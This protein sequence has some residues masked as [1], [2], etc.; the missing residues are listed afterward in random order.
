MRIE[1]GDERWRS[2]LDGGEK[3]ILA[4][5]GQSI[6]RP[7]Q[8]LVFEP[9]CLNLCISSAILLGALYLFFGAFQLVFGNI[10]EFS[11]WQRGCSFLGLLVG[12]ALAILSDRFWSWNYARLEQKQAKES[13]ESPPQPEWRLPPGKSSTKLELLNLSIRLTLIAIMGAPL[14]TIGLF[15]FAWT[16][17]PGVHWIGPIIGSGVFGAG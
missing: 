8:L 1:T 5:V 2:S 17:Y 4:T 3:S 12:M 14:V 6:Y 16:I 13:P 7:I 10:Y 9:M 11:L 15:I